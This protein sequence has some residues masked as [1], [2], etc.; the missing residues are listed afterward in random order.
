MF[1]VNG[2]IND[3]D[4][5][6]IFKKYTCGLFLFEEF[7]KKKQQPPKPQA[8]SPPACLY[9]AVSFLKSLKSTLDLKGPAASA[10][11]HSNQ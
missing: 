2:I 4:I 3:M 8:V 7:S 10:T 5:F 6:Q 11:N 9:D 1:S